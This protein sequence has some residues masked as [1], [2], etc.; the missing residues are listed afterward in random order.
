MAFVYPF[1]KIWCLP[2]KDAKIIGSV[3]IRLGE[4]ADAYIG[5]TFNQNYWH[6]GYATE[7]VSALIQLVFTQTK[8]SLVLAEVDQENTASVSLLK[9]LGFKFLTRKENI[10]NA[11]G[12]LIAEDTY[13]LEK[14]EIRNQQSKMIK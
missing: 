13:L 4:N 1:W 10:K 6:K 2:Q 8:L 5:Y 11:R 9:R 3:S 7:A 14:S 12:R